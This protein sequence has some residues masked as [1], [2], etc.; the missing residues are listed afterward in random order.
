MPMEA[1]V[2]QGPCPGCDASPLVLVA[3]QHGS[4]PTSWSST[5]VTSQNAAWRRSL[6]SRPSVPS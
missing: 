3:I 5:T 1:G 2:E 4:N 6:R